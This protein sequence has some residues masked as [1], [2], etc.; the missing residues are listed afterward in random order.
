MDSVIDRH[1]NQYGSYRQARA[2]ASFSKSV[3]NEHRHPPLLGEHGDEILS[4][5]GYSNER[6]SRL[7]ADQV[8]G[9]RPTR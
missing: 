4:E 7:H 5:L 9:Q 2:G 1:S 6:I 3:H 8:V